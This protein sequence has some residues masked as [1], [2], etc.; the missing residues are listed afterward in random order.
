[1]EAGASNDQVPVTAPALR[2]IAGAPA[3]EV[4]RPY[5]ELRSTGDADALL[6]SFLNDITETAREAEVVRCAR[7]T[8]CSLALLSAFPP[9]VLSCFKLNP[10]EHLNLRF[11]ATPEDVKRQYRKVCLRQH[12]LAVP[13][14]QGPDLADGAP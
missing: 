6:R 10:F 2:D 9:R 12:C 13:H 8:Q 7:Q 11:D 4:L 5:Q 14:S 1:M 3:G